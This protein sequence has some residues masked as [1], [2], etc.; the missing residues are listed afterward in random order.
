MQKSHRLFVVGGIGGVLTLLLVGVSLFTFSIEPVSAQGQ[1]NTRE[2]RATRETSA[3]TPIPR[4][5]RDTTR[6]TEIAAT[7]QAIATHITQSAESI[8][9]TATAITT[10]LQDLG[11]EIAQQIEILSE[12]FIINGSATY[13]PDTG[14]LTLIA[15][16]DEAPINAAIEMALTTSGYDNAV[17]VDFDG[18]SSTIIVTVEDVELSNGR[19]ATVALSYQ[20]VI[21]DD[22][23]TLVLV[24]ITVNGL[25]VPID[26]VDEDIVQIVSDAMASA[27]GDLNA[28]VETTAYEGDYPYTVDLILIS[29][30]TMT[31]VMTVYVTTPLP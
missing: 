18:A 12:Y 29:D 8:E 11:D 17:T 31:I 21:T 19:T 25:S 24:G 20:P 1:R 4:A 7:T 3:A 22:G 2:P 16:L 14:E 27:S 26:A 10:Q 9:M 15:V 23:V 30:D 6:V 5:T 28:M 13:D